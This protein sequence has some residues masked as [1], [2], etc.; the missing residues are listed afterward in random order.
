MPK[1]LA[2]RLLVA[3]RFVK[4]NKR[5]ESAGAD[6]TDNGEVVSSLT[7]LYIIRLN[8]CIMNVLK[9]VD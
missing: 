1:S 7:I 4:L 9:C 3:S 6:A 8:S 2:Q 5:K